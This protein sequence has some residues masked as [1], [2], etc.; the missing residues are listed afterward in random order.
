MDNLVYIKDCAPCWRWRYTW[1]TFPLW[2]AGHRKW[3][4]EL[5]M[6]ASICWVLSVFQVLKG[7]H[8]PSHLLLTKGLCPGLSKSFQY[9]SPQLSVLPC[10]VPSWIYLLSA[11]LCGSTWW[12][13]ME[14]SVGPDFRQNESRWLSHEWHRAS[15]S[16]YSS[17]SGIWTTSS[18]PQHLWCLPD[19]PPSSYFLLHLFYAAD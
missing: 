14:K 8:A 5:R 3:E 16:S 10:P 13:Q 11:I 18:S 6:L 1:L 9:S 19:W 7:W 12:Q 15:L 4:V 17:Q 2:S